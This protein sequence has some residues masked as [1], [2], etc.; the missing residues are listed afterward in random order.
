[1]PNILA[2]RTPDVNDFLVF[3]VSNA[4]YLTFDT[5]NGNA[6][7]DANETSPNTNY[8]QSHHASQTKMN[9]PL[10]AW[11]A[12]ETPPRE[13]GNASLQIVEHLN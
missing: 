7:I 4:K 10:L 9:S 13:Y 6:L 8:P 1:M 12:L 5:P 11:G 2:F 3:G